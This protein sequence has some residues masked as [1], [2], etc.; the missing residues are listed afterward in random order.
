MATIKDMA[1]K[2]LKKRK[3]E[4]LNIHDRYAGFI[5]GANAVLKEIDRCIPDES[6]FPANHTTVLLMVYNKIKMLKG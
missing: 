6:I 5:D 2:Y 3:G 1:K 4:V